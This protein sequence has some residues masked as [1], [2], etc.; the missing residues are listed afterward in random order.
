M[1]DEHLISYTLFCQRKK[2]RLYDF[3]TKNYMTY[4]EVQDF[5]RKKSVTPPDRI[6]YDRVIEKIN[7]EKERALKIEKIQ[8]EPKIN[9]NVSKSFEVKEA[10]KETEETTSKKRKRRRA[11]KSE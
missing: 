1:K 11:K 4:E 7:F 8:T 10:D 2:F 9:K 6:F 3:L 5:F